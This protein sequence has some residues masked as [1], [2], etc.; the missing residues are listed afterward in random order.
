M[1]TAATRVHAFGDDALGDHDAV[2]LAEEIR[3]GRVSR[4]EAVDAAIART[5]LVDEQLNG[6]AADRFAE[7]SA[8]AAAPADGFFAGQPTFV[9]D[10]SDVAGLPTQQ[11]THAY[12]ARPAA[13]DG[14]FARMFGLVGTTV[15]GKTRLSEYG[16]S[17][18]AE[19]VDD[20]P[21]RN[22]WHTGHTAGASS[23]GSAAF[24]AAGAVPMAHANDGGGSIRIPAACNGLVGLKATRG[25][26]PSD[27]LN[28]EMPVQIVHD[29]VVTRSVRDTAAFVRESERVYRNLKLPPV[30]DVTRPGKS[31][32]RIALVTNS[33]GRRMTDDET[34][35][36]VEKTAALLAELGHEIEVLEAPVPD[37]FEDDFLL[38]WA[39]LALAL[40][41]GGKI[42]FNRTYDRS[43][44]DNLTKGLARHAVK[45]AW[46]LPLAIARL[47][48]SHA[49]SKQFFAAHDVV[50][51]PT[52]SL[53]TPELG[54]LD[55]SQSYDTVMGRILEWVSFTPLQNATGDPAISLPMG[56]S[57]KGLPIGVQL[58]AAQGY[59]RRL[60][61][62]AYELEEAQP[63][64][65]IQD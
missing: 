13:A 65:R 25:R 47:R 15:L 8:E 52:L 41:A 43:T 3:A 58:S 50:L 44:N 18:S 35:Q 9:K 21:V 10:N 46:R 14:D 29:G 24:V 5:R 54:W 45:H 20:V 32:C 12:V 31:R 57:S 4:L 39:S 16:F 26:I 11:G 23:A 49:I 63:F 36:T 62:V 2:G 64:A 34:T 17:P 42:Q 27:K 7:A 30:G 59:D 40:S 28:R 33:I 1:T 48:R 56:T 22:P 6:L 53:T 61:A 60:I 55:P 51:T 19:F 37:S 38:Y